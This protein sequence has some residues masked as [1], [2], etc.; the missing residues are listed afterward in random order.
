MS[1]K[2]NTCGCERV[3]VDVSSV[4]VWRGEGCSESVCG[5]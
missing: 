1:V 4:S 3:S 5:W 2:V